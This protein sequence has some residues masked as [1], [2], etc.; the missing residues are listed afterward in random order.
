MAA[1]SLSGPGD[2]GGKRLSC[3]CTTAHSGGAQ[4]TALSPEGKAS[5]DAPVLY[6]VQKANGW[7]LKYTLTPG[8]WPS[9]LV[10]GM[11]GDNLEAWG[12]RGLRRG[13]WMTCESGHEH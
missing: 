5:S 11:A 8:Q 1:G 6:F 10:R 7:R 12:E 2:I 3:C 13:I 9:Q 4:K